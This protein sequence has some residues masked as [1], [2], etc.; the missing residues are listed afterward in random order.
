MNINLFFYCQTQ[1]L[2]DDTYY[3]LSL[4]ATKWT[5]LKAQA[6][7]IAAMLSSTAGW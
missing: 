7:K 5:S 6:Q 4:K 3:T 1:H 2:H